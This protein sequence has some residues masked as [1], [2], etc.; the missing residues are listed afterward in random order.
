MAGR[1]ARGHDVVQI[2][3]LTR[4]QARV[5]TSAWALTAKSPTWEPEQEVRMIFLVREGGSVQPTEEFRPDGTLRRYLPVPVTALRRMPVVEII[6]G[7]NNNPVEARE[8]AV[9]MLRRA[10]YPHP[11][12]KIVTSTAALDCD[13]GRRSTI[14]DPP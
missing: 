3:G 5:T 6:V 12:S 8:R 11:E 10:G 4:G 13:A 7:P 1:H 2:P 14:E 9:E